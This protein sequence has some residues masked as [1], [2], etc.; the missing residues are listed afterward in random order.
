VRI[1]RQLGASQANQGTPPFW[2][3]S[4]TRDTAMVAGLVF[5]VLGLLSFLGKHPMLS[6]ESI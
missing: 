6:V 3:L 2:S 5:R 4:H 1:L